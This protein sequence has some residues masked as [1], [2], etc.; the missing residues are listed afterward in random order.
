MSIKKFKNFIKN[1]IEEIK[2]AYLADNRPWVVGYSGGKDSTCVIQL[3]FYALQK[4][5][6]SKRKKHIY[7][8]SSDTLVETPLI[9]SYID[10]TLNSIQEEAKKN[11]LPISC[12]KVSPKIKETFWV[13]L[14]GQGYP[15]PRQK[16]RWCTHRLKIQPANDFIREKVSEFGEVIMVLGVRKGE[17]HSRDQVL[18]QHK[19]D[20][21]LLQKHTT[22]K[23]AYVYPPVINFSTED[24]WEYLLTYPSPWGGDNNKL[25]ELYQ[26]SSGECPLVTDQINDVQ[27]T[28]SCGNSRFGCW[29]C[30]VVKEDKALMGFIENDEEWL[31]PLLKFRNWLV[32]N[33]DNPS[34]RDNKRMNG[35]VY[36]IEKEGK[37]TRGLG[38]Y[39]LHGRQKI[40]REL[41]ETQK[42]LNKES[43]SP[44]TLTLISKEELHQIRKIWLHTGDWADTL[45]KIYREIFDKELDWNYDERPMFSKNEITYLEELCNGEKVPFE[46]IQK[47]IAVES[48]Y[49][50]YKLR[51]GILKDIGKVLNEQWIHHE[52]LT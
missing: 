25:V 34:L 7:V 16:F 47:L 23:N 48:D 11:D 21:R 39:H 49:Y 51:S 17:S 15:L 40:L 3:I 26:N 19:L 1:T 37:K 32:E 46:L 22:L 43:Q 4:I 41:L 50:G 35:H 29:V 27:Q 30:T 13:K 5:E 31:I 12:H 45:P 9:I 18:N 42:Q 14:I 20:G 8:I 38:P 44:M 6:K 52:K 10:N 28:A 33:R 24:V 36:Y 2:Y